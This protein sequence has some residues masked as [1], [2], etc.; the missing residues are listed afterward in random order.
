MYEEDVTGGRQDFAVSNRLAITAIETVA[1]GQ[2]GVFSEEQ[3]RACGV[4]P[5]MLWH[6]TRRG[7]R[8]RL[9]AA[10]VYELAEHPRD[11]RRPLMAAALSLGDGGR[12]SHRSAGQLLRVDGLHGGPPEVIVARGR[13]NPEWRLHRRAAVPVDV[14]I[15]DGIPH[16]T[17][18]RT[19]RDLCSV[20]DEDHLEMALESAL[21]L[22]YMTVGDFERLAATAG[23][24]GVT[25]L[26]AVLDRRPPG[27]PPTGSE[28]ETRFVQL[29]RVLGLP[30]PERQYAV[31]LN[32]EVIALL[33]LCW[34]EVGLFVELDGG[35]HE[36]LAALRRDRQRQ[37]DVVR[38]LGW[39]P[40]R[41]TWTDV[42]QRPTV[43]GRIVRQAHLPR[44]SAL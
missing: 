6:H 30:D 38:L 41:F 22:G 37:N 26:R 9:T 17:P 20:L 21:R 32:G 7:R 2:H 12:V 4:T 39:R 27:A 42:V 28:L 44:A 24:K 34:P 10:R 16:T 19:L 43:T 29:V 25:R 1:S 8:W 15:T 35:V 31:V 11:W 14:T 3:A 40:L 33:D 5:N 18:A 36:Q 23:W 13:T